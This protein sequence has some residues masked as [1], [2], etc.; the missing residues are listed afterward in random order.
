MKV[1]LRNDV[2]G[3]GTK[4]DIVDV[5][6]GYARNYLVPQGL[7][8]KATDG[9][10]RQA[11][12]MRRSRDI[13]ASKNLAEAQELAARFATTTLVIPA[14]AGEGGKLFGSITT[15][16]VADAAKEQAHA[17]IDRHVL[18]IDEPIKTLGEHTVQAHPHHDVTFDIRV[19][20]VPEDA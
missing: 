14:R 17:D 16:N 2:D 18:H 6:D 3:L 20:V 13:Q 12:A 7:A 11:E 19:N 5:A 1:V 10:E 8:F 9:A 15:T 4:G